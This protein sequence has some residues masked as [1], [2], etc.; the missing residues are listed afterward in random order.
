MKQI[1][2]RL[3]C[4]LFVLLLSISPMSGCSMNKSPVP[5][6]TEDTVLK[7]YL[8]GNVQ[9]IDDVLK[10]FERQTRNTLHIKLQIVGLTSKTYPDIMPLKL[11]AGEDA[12][13]VFDA[14]WMTLNQ[15]VSKGMYMDLEKYFNNDKY[16][17]I[18]KAF[19]KEFLDGNRFNGKIF[20]V[21]L[22]QNYL[23]V[24]GV[25]YRKDLLK[26]Y[27]LGFDT[28]TSMK[29]LQEFY[30]AVLTHEKKIAPLSVGLRGFYLMHTHNLDLMSHN[31]FDITGWN[32]TKYPGKIVL[33]EDGKTVKDVVFAGDDAS[34]FQALGGK[35]NYDFFKKAY[36]EQASWNKYLEEDALTTANGDDL[37][38]AGLSASTECTLSSN[39][40]EYQTNLSVVAPNAE[41]SFFAYDEV[42]SDNNMKPGA[43]PSLKQAWNFI[44]IPRYSQ[45]SD[46]AMEFL[47]WLFAK[48]E[49]M[50][51]FEFGLEG[52][53]W[54]HNGNDEYSTLVNTKGKYTFP[55]YELAWNPSYVRTLEGLKDHEK[56]ILNYVNDEK[57]YSP[58]SIAGWS[59]DTSKISIEIAQLSALYEESYTLFQEGQY[60]NQ[61]QAK[62]T[63][64]HQRSEEMGLENVRKAI[65]EQVQNYLNTK[66]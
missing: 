66:K 2:K 29:Q 21:P 22:A 39:T 33:S 38:N 10:E 7:I 11:A 3:V 19:S 18:K 58:V 41:C 8:R 45:N 27:N 6:D 55:A 49:H 36:F 53:D 48:Q 30:D 54:L 16:P 57:S 4:L 24:P 40:L 9:N 43:I 56:K 52:S 42:F 46:K 65:K 20:G 62:L 5:K 50:E 37:F 1:R 63:E 35:Y 25:V 61:T 60:G 64:F 32:F 15:M 59:I 14:P 28:I 34:R 26:K 44:C 23:D 31:I 47:N 12:D 51:L 13:L 17:G